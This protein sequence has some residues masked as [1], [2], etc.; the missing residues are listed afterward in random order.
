MQNEMIS[1]LNACSFIGGNAPLQMPEKLTEPVLAP[2]VPEF[3][4]HGGEMGALISAQDWSGTALGAPASWPRTLKSMLATLLSSPQPMII[5]WGSDLLSFFNDSYRPMLGLRFDGLSGR[6]AAEQW[7]ASWAE[8]EPMAKKAL[9]GEGSHYENMPFTLTRNGYTVPTWWTLSF[10]PFR[11]DDGAV[12][13]VYCFPIETTQNVLIEQRRE[14]EQKR[15]AFRV[16][17]GDALRDAIEPKSLMMAAAE[18]LGVHLHAACV[19]HGEIDASGERVQIHH[20]W[21]AEGSP[22]LVGAHPLDIYGPAVIAGLRAG[23]TVVVNDTASDPL[24]AWAACDAAGGSIAAR[25]FVAAPLV[26]NGR[27]ALI[28]FVLDPRPRLWTHDEKALVEEVAERT[29][30]SLARLRAELDVHQMNRTLDQRTTEL[31]RAETA[32]RQSQKLEA[33]GQL[34]GGVA[35]DFNNLLAVISSSVELLRSNKLPV[36]RHGYY[37]DLIYDTVGRAV[38]LTGQLLA[39]ARQEPLSPEVFDVDLQ[40]QVVVDLVRPLMGRQVNILYQPCG[41]NACVAE[42]DINQFETALVNLAINARDAMSANGQLIINVQQ[43]GSLPAGPGHGPRAGDFIAISVSDTGCGIASEKLEMIF[44]PFYTT[45]AVGKGTGLGLSQ[46]FGFAKQS[47]GAVHVRSELGRGSVFTLYLPRAESELPAKAWAQ[48]PEQGADDGGLGVLVVE[49]NETLAQMTCEILDAL[50]YRTVWAVNAASALALLA[51][52]KNRFDLVFS[53]V[54]MPGMN[55]IEFGEQVRKHH[56]GLPVVLASGYNAVMAEQG[57]HG[58]E[59]ILKPYTTDTLVRVFRKAIAEQTLPP[60][61]SG[62]DAA[63]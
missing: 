5:G 26:K 40:V 61:L 35:H 50:G 27:L 55:G 4:A 22:A 44:E 14:Q 2:P 20:A 42:A 8:L 21:M 30:T 57:P 58:F 18:K 34:T 43:T 6:P 19:G 29:W 16:K 32:L 33:L 63:G 48:C 24:T 10:M 3:L 28:F 49:D 46:V 25:A 45:K 39:F 38:K 9:G 36:E 47:G 41:R 13:G 11:D 12:V 62:S 56:P 7:T 37:L 1:S 54:V 51:G 23:R 60:V 15:Q 53:D 17:L 59:L 52:G 31:L